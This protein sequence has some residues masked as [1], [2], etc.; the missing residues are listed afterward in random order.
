[1]Y[2]SESTS[3]SVTRCC[4]ICLAIFTAVRELNSHIARHLER[5][6]L[7]SLPR[8]AG[9]DADDVDQPGSNKPNRPSDTSR[10][11]DTDETSAGADDTTTSLPLRLWERA[12]DE[13]KQEEV[14]LVDAYEKILSRQLQDGPGST[15]PESQPN[16]IAQNTLNRRRQMT[17]LIN[18]GLAKTERE[19]NVK[20]SLGVT[21]LVDVVLSAKN[22]I[23]AAI[24]AVPQAALAWTG[25]CIVLEMFLNPTE[26]TEANRKGIDYVI[27]KIDWYWNLSTTLSFLRDHTNN[28]SELDGMRGELENRIVDLYKALLSYQIKS[29]CAYYRNRGL[30]FLRDMITLDDWK[31]DLGAIQDAEKYFRDDTQTYTPQQVTS[32]LEQL[33][34]YTMS[35]KDQ[36]CLKHL[37]LTD[38]RDDKVRIERTKGILQDSYG[39][40]F[41]TVEFVQWRNV[42]QHRLLWIRGKPGQG[43]TMLLCGIINKLDQGNTTNVRH[44]NVAYFF[45]QAT[46]SRINN[47][48]AVLRGLIYLLIEQQPSVLSHVRKEYDRTGENLFVDANAWYALSKIFT[49]ILQDPSLRTTYL[50]IDALDECTSIEDRSQLL[51]LIAQ[52]SSSGSRVK[53]IVSSR[54]LNWPEIEGLKGAD[55][56]IVLEMSYHVP[57]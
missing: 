41:N 37:R 8:S 30:V 13:L 36:Q 53:W 55:K 40:V 12:Y 57:H 45:C 51:D 32:H 47:A 3:Q 46:D 19:V 33:V 22:T 39:W 28:I 2:G 9:E 38:P 23:S 17:Q 31:A 48:A 34:S 56:A 15:V 29:V 21:V 4:P 54:R 27:K 50:I 11:G 20:E 42:L 26:A 18:A 6:S 5:F 25:I 24:Q 49:N 43:K 44:Y 1:M 52:Q 7:F 35:K 14:K 10:G 16:T